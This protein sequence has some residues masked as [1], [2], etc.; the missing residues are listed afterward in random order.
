MMRKHMFLQS[1]VPCIRKRASCMRACKRLQS[2]M[3]DTVF[4]KWFTCKE[5]PVAF[6][7][8]RK[9]KWKQK[10]NIYWKKIFILKYS[11][12]AWRACIRYLIRFLF[13]MNISHVLNHIARRTEFHVTKFAC[14]RLD[15]G[16]CALMNPQVRFCVC[17]KWTL[18]AFKVFCFIMNHPMIICRTRG[19]EFFATNLKKHIH[20]ILEVLFIVYLP[21][22]YI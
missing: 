2:C 5:A 22:N 8:L 12:G 10:I 4:A 7:T 16:M 21:F 1:I 17:T 11:L 13:F 18:R 19:F 6:I 9:W 14:V 20:L 15:A 3:N